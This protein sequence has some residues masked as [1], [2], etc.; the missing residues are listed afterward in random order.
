MPMELLRPKR[1]RIQS[2]L[3]FVSAL[4]LSFAVFYVDLSFLPD[5]I[6]LLLPYIVVLALVTLSLGNLTGAIFAAL[7]MTLWVA[8][9]T[10]LFTLLTDHSILD[11]FIKAVFLVMLFSLFAVIN[12]LNDKTKKLATEDAL[13]GIYNRRGFTLLASHELQRL[14]R[15]HRCL[16]FLF[17]DVDDFKAVNDRKGHKEGDAVLR[18][19]SSIIAGTT[20]NIDIA[21]RF[22]GD[23]FCVLLPEVDETE[24][25]AI[26]TRLLEAFG[27]TCRERSWPT[28]LSVGA[29]TT[30]KIGDL[31][32]LIAR[33]D[34]LMYMAKRKGR[35]RA[36]YASDTR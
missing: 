7:T 16:S 22:G 32:S 3:I 11:I 12:R 9:S 1:T 18:E 28:S 13:C 33:G 20:R 6:T 8:S 24:L 25:K 15:S 14:E 29:L 17:I 21:A 35:G 27:K 5:D 23:E 10:R 36:M 4:A 2:V 34:E 19:V 30:S 31:E 26:V